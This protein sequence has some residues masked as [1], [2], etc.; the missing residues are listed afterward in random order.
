MF[1]IRTD[2][3]TGGV[4]NTIIPSYSGAMFVVGGGG[5]TFALSAV[6]DL[7]R[8][9][10]LSNVTDID[11]IWCIADPGLFVSFLPVHGAQ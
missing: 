9:G 10:N 11:I 5:V 1:H 8:S 6:Q 3:S 4:G 2:L 7:V